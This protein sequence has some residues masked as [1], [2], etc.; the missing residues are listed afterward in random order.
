MLWVAAMYIVSI[1][2]T[3]DM[4]AETVERISWYVILLL[5]DMD[6]LICRRLWNKPC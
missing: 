4:N 5:L 3:A 1:L 6:R 2:S